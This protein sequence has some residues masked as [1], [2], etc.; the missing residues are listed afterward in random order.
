MMRK[1]TKFCDFLFIFLVKYIKIKAVIYIFTT[2][3]LTLL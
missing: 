3:F 1:L 2:S